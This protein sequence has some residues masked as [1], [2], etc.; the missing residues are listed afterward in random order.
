MGGVVDC[1][2]GVDTK[3]S[4]RHA[5]IE[6]AQAELQK[7]F[8]LREERRRELEFL[9]KGGNPLD[10][11]F[12]H[13]ASGSVQ[14]TSYTDQLA[15]PYATSE[16]KGSF[17][18]AASPHGDSVESSGRP[19][20]SIGREPNIGDNLLLLDGKN[21]KH[22]EK[23]AK[24]KGKRGSVVL[25]EQSSQVDGSHNVK[26]TEDSVIFRVGAKSQAYARRN[27]S[28]GSRDCA[29]LGLTDSSSRH[30]N[31]ASFTSSYMPCPRVTKGPV[32]GL[33]AEDHAVSSI[34]NSKAASLEGI[35]IPK[36]LNTDGLVDMQLN[37]VQNNHICADMMIDGLPEG[38]KELKITENIQG[39]DICD[40][41]SS[42]PEKASNGT[43]PQSCDIIG[44]DDALS[45]CLSSNP[46]E[47]NESKKDP[48][49]AEVINKC[50][51][52]EKSTD[53]FDHDDDL[54]H[55][56]FVANA[57]TENLNADITEANT[58]VDGTCNI[59]ENTDGDQS[60][61]LRTDGSSNGD[62]K[63]QT[64]NIGIWSMPDD[65]TL[66]ENKPVDA[67]VPIA[68]NDRSR[69]VQPDVNNS[70]VQINNEVCDSRTEMQSEVTPI[71]NSELV[72]L[73]DEIICEAEKKMNNFVGDSNCTRK[74]G[75]GASFLV[76]STCESSEAILV[77]KSS[78]STTEL[79]TSA[80]DH[81]K[82]HEDATLKEARLI[83]ARLRRAAE[84]SISYKNS[85]KRQKCHW[86]FVLEEMAWM[87]ND[88]MQERLW[89]ISAAA[90]VSRW[91]ASCGQEKFEQVNIWRKQKNVARSVAK[92]VMH[93]W[94]EAEVIHTGDMAPNAVH[95]KCESD[96]LRLSNIN[97][98]EI[99]RNQGRV[100]VLDY[101]VKFLKHNSSTASYAI[102]AEAPTA[103]KRQ[104]DATNL[105]IPCED[106][107]SEESLFY[108]IPPGAMQ[109]YRESIES[110]WLHCKKF[111]N[112]L[113]QDDCETSNNSVAGGTQDNIYD[114]DEGETG[115]YLLPG[116][117][118][119]GLSS[120]LSHKKQKHMRQKSTVTRLNEGGTHLSHE[121]HLE[122]KSGNQPFILNGKRTLNTFSL[123]SIPTKRVKRATRQ[124]V[125][126]PY[127][128]GVNGPLQVTTKT[129]VS[130]EDTSSFQDDQDS[131]HG[132]YMHR[133]NL[134]V[135]ST[136]DFE[137]QLQYDGN[138]IS[139]TSKKKK[140]KPNNFGYRN[141]LNLT[142][143]DLLV[144]P[145]K[146]SIQGCL[147]EQRLH[148]DPVIQHEQKEHVKKRTESQNFDSNGGTVV[149]GQ[150]AAK[151][152]KL[153]KQPLEASLEA[154]TPPVASSLP[155]PVDSQMSNMSNSNKLV[156]LIANRDRVRKS[157]ALKMAA[158]QSGSG[159]LW[160]NFEDQALVVLVH[161]M[162]PNWELVSD[163]INS[164]L[165]FK[166]IFRK[167]K[168]CKERHKFL[169]D[170]SAG[171]GADSTED[172]GS[173]QPY[174]ST[175]PGIPK[176]SARQLFQR[177]QGPMEEDILKAHFE[178]I[179][180]LGQKLSSYTRQNDNQEQKPMTPAHTSHV[181]ALSH[182]CPNN[183]NGGILTPLDF[184]ESIS[185]SPDAFPL[186]YQGPHAGSLG[187]GNHQGPVPPSLPTS[188][189]STMLQGS[190]GMGLTS[191]LTPS[192]APLNSSYRDSQRYG[193]PRS[194]SSPVD[195][196]QRMQQYSQML[197][198]RNPQQSSMTLS[199][200]LPVGVDRSVRMLP[201]AGGMGM[202]PG[203]N[204][205][206]PMPR[207]SFQ[208]ISSP[209]M[210]NMVSTGNML[211]SGGQG[212]KNSV[213]VHPSA[214]CSPGN[215]MMR[216]RD[217][218]QMLRPGQIAEEHR[219]MMMPELQ[220]QVSQANGQSMSPFSGMSASFSN[221]TLPASVPTFSIQQHQQSHQMAQQ[222]HM[223][224]N[225]HHH[226][227]STSHSS[228]QQQAYAMRVAKE[229][230]LQHRIT[231]QS[232]HINGPNAVTP[233][234]NNSQ[235]QPQSQSCSPV[236]PVSSS[237]G[238]QKQQNLLRN[239]PSGISNQIMKQRQ[240]QVQQHQP[241]Q[242]QQQRQ[243][244]QQQTKL[245]K[246]LGR[247][248]MLNH[249]NISADASQLSGFST[250]SKNRVSD[251]HLMHQGQGVFPGSPCLNPSWHQSGSQTN[252]Y[253]HPLPQSAKQSS[254]MSDTCNQGSAPSSPS[255]NILAS[256]QASIPSSMPLLKQHQ[257]PQQH[258]LNQSHQSIQ[259][260]ALQQSRQINPSGRM[261][262][263]SD[264][265]QINQIVPSA[266]I[267]QC[268]DSG[269]S[270]SA[271]SSATLWNPEP[272][273][274]KNT[275]TPIAHVASS[276][277]ENLVGSEA[278][279]PSSGQCLV[280]P[281]QLSGGVSE[282]GHK[283]GGQWQ[284]Q[285]Q[286]Q[287]HHQQEQQHSQ[288]QNQQMVQSDLYA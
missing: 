205:G 13:A 181:V 209:G 147:Y 288:H 222:Q 39:N 57:T 282:H 212:V 167:P 166:C 193:I 33:P 123:G 128:C 251:K 200:S 15:E 83:E 117:F 242:Q 199:G 45:V 170:K 145:G 229:R 252:I 206:I 89:K 196:P 272:L 174:P 172:S 192:S 256:Q 152:P 36:A 142:D 109:A 32:S 104:N 51:I 10:F 280:P 121:P 131:L 265:S 22:G 85:E 218:L 72:K 273:Y 153:L 7:E 154:L 195:D 66:K 103:P 30:G 287:P 18:L 197:S 60:L 140:K 77:T 93:F 243:H 254:P 257:Q 65:S 37:L 268:T 185:S 76:S 221:V 87:A 202:M 180:L 48:C 112:S 120:K 105:K 238:Q 157:K 82:A 148:V 125:V 198:G 115:T 118:E 101:A 52:P 55:K 143:P 74:A 42:F 247:G 156:K 267:P 150:H 88:F 127:P 67:D 63:D 164:T 141:S 137:K 1:G 26:E 269:T 31:K 17:T 207:P 35:V 234:Q 250:A 69:S 210:L 92:A 179:I 260:T 286:Q 78:A 138:E 81:K 184:C 233:V 158:G 271:V 28:R 224:G 240:R 5:A 215:S 108:T 191:S 53:C 270:A 46:L 50:G 186:G 244:T 38:G 3:T 129:D 255:H 204:R 281:Q 249:H 239:P 237:Q 54:H 214:I 49:G 173:S 113:H 253:T 278:L 111:G 80:S 21:N 47:F 189:V 25:S 126:S 259:R 59:H 75:I 151:K 64:T 187:V 96:R 23:N 27:R 135:G 168:E 146:A 226:I 162:G 171:D 91:I 107:L 61:M 277:Q 24:H 213:N 8:D 235:M 217:S 62:I 262:S 124:R 232:Q 86:D 283:S 40:Q 44:K 183:V 110:Q 203:V 155:S 106:Q 11:K 130:S 219:Q 163:A 132:G 100:S 14:S 231:P 201:G 73:N 4:P 116:T 276:P 2:L 6:K 160:S 241:R 279:V 194:S 12:S 216:P 223:L 211:S 248:N 261:Q 190:P 34:S 20:G 263:S 236:T 230:Q 70:V 29:N 99:E 178:K 119:G 176:G 90:Q 58:C 95:D 114:E 246:D 97:G 165:Q 159:S 122:I 149:Y 264:Q 208:G 175:L 84:L 71:T 188:G 285:Q 177:L 134:G 68:A 79:D 161:D 274:D 258:Y 102:L 136:M 284:L 139:S 169:M 245:M 144:V 225:P 16:A 275:P 133:K 182:V 266:S 19:G 228:P 227:Q 9:E 56:T 98:T 41:H 220:L 43:L 94:N